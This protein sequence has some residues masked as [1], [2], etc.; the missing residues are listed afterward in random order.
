MT[1]CADNVLALLFDDGACDIASAAMT[2][3]GGALFTMHGKI[4]A[5]AVSVFLLSGTDGI[6]TSDLRLLTQKLDSAGLQ[7][8]SIVLALSGNL[9]LH[10]APD[11]LDAQSELW[12]AWIN[13]PENNLAVTLVAA[14]AYGFV[15]TLPCL[16]D[17]AFFVQGDGRLSLSMASTV[18]Q[19][20]GI[21][22]DP[23]TLGGALVHARSTGIA[24][25]ISPHL[26]DAVIQS[27][28]YLLATENGSD[29]QDIV[30]PREFKPQSWLDSLLPRHEQNGA[31]DINVLLSS[32]L[33]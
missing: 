16:A 23:E 11:L 12:R 18:E 6:T 15:A 30:R 32:V 19:A 8:H 26:L 29:G 7:Q 4:G 10:D 24:G 17:T 9:M 21:R 33:D 27:R 2:S 20:L 1:L 31:Y 25:V 13:S 5:R 28:R 14:E 22:Q 3:E